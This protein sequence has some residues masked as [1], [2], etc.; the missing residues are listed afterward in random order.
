MTLGKTIAFHSYKGGTGKT[1]LISNL[2]ALYAKNGKTVCLLDFDLYAPSLFAY[3]R[4]SPSCYLNDLLRGEAGI[5]DI[6]VDVTSELGLNGKLL[7]GFSSP[8][9]EDINEIEIKHELKW[10]LAAMRRVLAAKNQL[11]EDSKIDYL[12]LDTSPGIRYWSINAL[13]IA[14]D[15]FLV[16]KISDMDIEGTKRMIKDIYDSLTRFGSRYYLILNKVPGA[17]PNSEYFSEKEAVAAVVDLERDTGSRVVASI[18]CFCDINF[19]RH[20]FL[21][22]VKQPEHL[23]SKKLIGLSEAIK[24]L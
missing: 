2:A 12:L 6:L 4:K 13:A 9:K 19:N 14:D 16:M 3:F 17:S 8:R 18:P 1:T 24:D 21:S 15:L 23:F 11:F 7:V 5:S 22:A 10:Q 20:E